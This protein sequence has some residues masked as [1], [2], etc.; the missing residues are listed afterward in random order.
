MAVNCTLYTF[1]KANNSTAKPGSN[2]T[3]LPTTG[4]FKLGTNV[5]QPSIG[6]DFG[7]AAINPTSYNYAYISDFNRYYFIRNWVYSARLWY[8]EMAV[9]VLGTY[10]ADIGDSTQYVLR[11][12]SKEEGRIQDSYYPMVTGPTIT[13][14]KSASYFSET[15]SYVLGI[16][17]SE[18]SNAAGMATYY[19]LTTAQMG[20]LKNAL[21]SS[22]SWTDVDDISENMLR[23]YF[24][25]LDYIISATWYPFDLSG[26]SY[27][28]AVTSI[29]LGW[30][31]F[32]VS[33][34]RLSVSRVNI[35]GNVAVPKHPQAELRG[36]YLNHAPY[37]DYTLY[38]YP[39]G[40]FPISD[41]ELSSSTQI[42][43]TITTDIPSG[44]GYLFINDS[45]DVDHRIFSTEA[46]IGVQIPLAQITTDILGAS[47]SA[48]QGAAQ[49]TQG[50]TSYS[51]GVGLITETATDVL[52]GV[53]TLAGTIGNVANSLQ[54]KLMTK[55]SA[56]SV[57]AYA[58]VNQTR[59]LHLIGTFHPIVNGDT[60]HVGRPLCQSVKLSTLS[61]FIACQAPKIDFGDLA[62]ER[63]MIMRYLESGFFME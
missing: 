35:T 37:S 32:A 12:A 14:S 42:N 6:F 23:T 20:S 54:P 41:N 58:G 5:L 53:S 28:S 18:K 11:S 24:N 17:N 3:S 13:D 7:S 38:A 52:A 36:V 27:G 10:K 34:R 47:V 48:V 9:D 29:Q 56:G 4:V 1:N 26:S 22:P 21:M 44:M 15:G 43:F 30:W 19:V 51:G 59:E 49:I 40:S 61:G 62:T 31:S 46:M 25:P 57:G 33:A 45:V 8:A 50:F 39:F 2:A 16:E 60:E 63:D 55:G